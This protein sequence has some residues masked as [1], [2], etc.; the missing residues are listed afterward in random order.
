[1]RLRWYVLRRN[2]NILEPSPAQSAKPLSAKP[3]GCSSQNKAG[4]KIM[5]AKKHAESLVKYFERIASENGDREVWQ[6]GLQT[7]QEWLRLIDSKNTSKEELSTFIHI[8]HANRYRTSGWYD[9]ALGAY[10]WVS[11]QGLSLM[12]PKEFFAPDGLPNDSTLFDLTSLEHAR[13]LI[14]IFRQNSDED[15]S[16]TAWS[17]GIQ[18]NEEWL[19][20]I[21]KD[22]TTEVEVAAL[23]ENAITN[24]RK[25]SSSAWFSTVLTISLWSKATGYLHLVPDDFYYLVSKGN[26]PK[27]I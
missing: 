12:P 3:L 2:C 10:H 23:I 7:A 9:L 11:S 20:L 21:E 16:N 13:T 4:L 1:L 15:P 5:D 18:V 26:S 17:N 8:V 25:Y 6:K 14:E 24:Q 27:I 22:G 19:K